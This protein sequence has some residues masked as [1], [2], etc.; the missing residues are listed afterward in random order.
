MNNFYQVLNL[1]KNYP[2]GVYYMPLRW[3]INPFTK[4]AQNMPKEGTI[5]D[6][7]C[8]E[9][10]LAT[11]LALHS[12]NR[13]VIGIDNDRYKIKLGKLISRKIPNLTFKLQN[14]VTSKLT[15]ANGFVLTDFLHHTPYNQHEKILRK[16]ANA[17]R[18]GGV[19][20]IKE[21]DSGEYFR[22]KMARFW[23][24]EAHEWVYYRVDTNEI[25]Y[26][27]RAGEPGEMTWAINEAA[28]INDGSLNQ[29]PYYVTRREVDENGEPEN[30]LRTYRIENGQETLVR[31]EDGSGEILW[32]EEMNIIGNVGEYSLGCI[33]VIAIILII[34]GIIKSGW[35]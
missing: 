8:G 9:G 17:T 10:V 16:I 35:I 21:V 1:Y 14:L 5:V 33:L 13:Q 34:Y 27:P 22:S 6:L 18:K 4:I 32:D 26:Q 25:Y 29:L 15:K 24:E 19:V 23:D 28:G 2:H 7:G 3:V 20:I 11:L 30:A 31:V 12:K